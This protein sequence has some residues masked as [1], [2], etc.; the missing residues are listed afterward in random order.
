MDKLLGIYHIVGIII[1]VSGVIGVFSKFYVKSV[2]ASLHSQFQVELSRTRQSIEEK[3]DRAL[4]AIKNT[5]EKESN[6]E[7]I[8]GKV[9]DFIDGEVKF[10]EQDLKQIKEI[11]VDLKRIL[12]TQQETLI[13]IQMSV[14][15][16]KP[17]MDSLEDRIKKLEN[18]I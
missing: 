10:I 11:T 12:A 4:E 14:T 18:N 8:K 3:N 9:R 17:R 5:I 7:S 15:E 2:T 6:A 13:A 1:S 16:L